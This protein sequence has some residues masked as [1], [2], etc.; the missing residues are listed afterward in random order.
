MSDSKVQLGQGDGVVAVL[1]N[2]ASLFP[3]GDSS[4]P[5]LSLVRAEADPSG[6]ELA[7]RLA[8]LLTGDQAESVPAFGLVADTPDGLLVFLHGQ[9][10]AAVTMADGAQQHLSGSDAATWVDRLYGSDVIDVVVARA[11]QQP[12]VSESSFE[13]TGGVVPAGWLRVVRD[14]GDAAAEPPAETP[15]VDEGPADLPPVAEAATP[16]T[17]D[18]EPVASAEDAPAVDPGGGPASGSVQDGPPAPQA[19]PGAVG[20]EAST[21]PPP[22]AATPVADGLESTDAEPPTADLPLDFDVAPLTPDTGTLRE[23]LPVETEPGVEEPEEDE[24]ELVHGILCSRQHFNSPDALYCSTCGI[25]M[26]HQTH[27]LVRRRRPPLGFLVFD[28]GTTF[29]LDDRY[30][31]GREPETDPLVQQGEARPITL[32]DPQMS[33]SRVHAE[34]RLVGWDVQLVD[35]GSTNGSYTLNAAGDGWDRLPPEEPRTVPRGARGA[36]GQRTFV[37]ESPQRGGQ[38]AT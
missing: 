23:P 33:V 31:L 15:P 28:D 36:V 30:V 2:V 6:R 3:G 22:P 10:D 32:Q 34:I 29:T 4:E 13:L 26:V 12:A 24:R 9:V 27:N 37:Y 7:R 18:P 16:S 21:T 19:P 20:D 5:V 14:A 11:G 35:R 17:P 38:L 1:D 8:G 25:A